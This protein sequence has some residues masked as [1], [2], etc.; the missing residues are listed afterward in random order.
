MGDELL[1]YELE[2]WAPMPPDQGPPLPRFLNILWPWYKEELP[3]E[4]PPAG[5]YECPYCDDSFD[6]LKELIDH[7]AEAHPDQPPLQEIEIQW[8]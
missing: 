2:E 5:A 1:G 7:V 8:E 6:T 3:P 4:E